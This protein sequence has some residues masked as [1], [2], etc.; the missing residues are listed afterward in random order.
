M[1]SMDIPLKYSFIYVLIASLAVNVCNKAWGE[2]KPTKTPA[3]SI[4]DE[5]MQEGVRKRVYP[6]AVLVVGQPGKVLWAQ[7]YGKLNYNPTAPP[8][9]LDTI[10]DLASVS[11][12]IGTAT[13]SMLLIQDGKLNLD[14]TA[15]KFIH[16]FEAKGKDSIT[17]RDLMTHVSGLKAYA[18]SSIIEKERRKNQSKADAVIAYYCAL[19]P[20]YPR[21]TKQLY[22][23]INMQIMARVV[24]NASGERMEDILRRR[25]WRPLGMLNTG[26]VLSA[27]QKARCAPTEL[28]SDGSFL[29]GEVHDPLASYYGS[30]QHCP[31]NA[32]L[33]STGPDL[34]RYCEMILGE[35]TIDGMIVFNPGTIWRMTANESPSEVNSKRGLGWG[36]YEN[37]S[38]IT[39]LNDTNATHLIG[40][41]GFTGTQ[42]LVDKLSN[43]YV[44]FLT[45]YTLPSKQKAPAGQ[46]TLEN[47]RWRVWQAVR[48]NLTKYQDY[49]TSV[50]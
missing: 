27:S 22:S 3:L 45:N 14:D 10:Y 41:T 37:K 30:V 42:I 43:T 49:F 44:V 35:G 24:E 26:Y 4:L 18:S 40:H 38:W 6:G 39:P 50:K 28:K 16:G 11:K 19:P 25:V 13:A 31:G 7:A 23:C 34:A 46:P 36:I 2:I 21:R 12:V 5:I 32:G 15:A 48:Q 29:Q 47:L 33:F 1:K 8:A 9:T 17:I 20:V